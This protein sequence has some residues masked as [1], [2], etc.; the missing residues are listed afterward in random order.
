MK[1][2]LTLPSE[3]SAVNPGI[4]IFHLLSLEI[5]DSPVVIRQQSGNLERKPLG[6]IRHTFTLRREHKMVGANRPI[7]EAS[8]YPLILCDRGWQ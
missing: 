3:T 7:T 2:P 5:P 8:H 1:L 4:D 6:Y